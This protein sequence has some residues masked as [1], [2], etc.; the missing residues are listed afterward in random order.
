MKRKMLK[1]AAAL[2]LAVLMLSSLGSTLAFADANASDLPLIT[3]SPTG[4]TVDIGG[5]AIFVAK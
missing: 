4:E 1:S 3:K 5:E 2:L